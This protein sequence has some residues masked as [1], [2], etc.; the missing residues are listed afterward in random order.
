VYFTKKEK[1]EERKER[2]KQEKQNLNEPLILQEGY[3]EEKNT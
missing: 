3:F 1:K 2:S